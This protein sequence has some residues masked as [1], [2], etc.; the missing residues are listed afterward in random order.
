[1]KEKAVEVFRHPHAP[2]HIYDLSE[3]EVRKLAAGSNPGQ[4]FFHLMLAIFPI[5]ITAFVT[6]LTVPIVDRW[7]SDLF[8]ILTISCGLAGFILLFL[9]LDARKNQRPLL[10]QILSR[11]IEGPLGD[12]GKELLSAEVRNYLNLKGLL[13]IKGK[14]SEGQP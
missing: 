6:L 11:P 7:K 3:D 13:I 10:D 9:W 1:M 2:I 12:D 4:I 5:G 14:K 8:M